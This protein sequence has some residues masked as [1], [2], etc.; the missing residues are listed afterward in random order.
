MKDKIILMIKGFFIGVANVIPGVSGGTLA[1]TMGIYEQLIKAVS[2]FFSD[3]KENIKLVI[4]V[5]LGAGLAI[6][7][8]SKII[9]YSLEH[10]PIPTT[11]F[12]IELILGGMPV[13]FKKVKNHYKSIPNLLIFLITFIIV[14]SLSFLDSGD[15]VVNFNNLNIIG[16]I[17]LFLV[18]M[19][20]AATMVIPGIS[21]SF[22]LMLLGYYKPIIDT[23]SDLTNFDNLV[24]NILILFP[25]GMGILIGIVLISKI[26]EYLLKK[27][28]IKTYCAIIGIVLASIIL[29][30]KPLLS[31]PYDF[32]QIV[33]SLILGII[34][35]FIA[36]KLGDE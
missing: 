18:G 22:I 33:I 29:I 20:S 15:R 11:I 4:S 25:F 31:L 19:I 8:M 28:E 10:Y 36:Y 32:I 12:F 30:F 23:I 17:I 2:H 14:I 5:G 13:I 9:G 27:H 34:G 26:I 24:N 21:G 3:L 7:L 1:I 6:L 35:Y 16:Y